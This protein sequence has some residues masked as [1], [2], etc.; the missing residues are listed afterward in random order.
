[1]I[2]LQGAGRVTQRQKSTFAGLCREWKQ[3]KPDSINFQREENPRAMTARA[4]AYDSIV[5][6]PKLNVNVE[7][8]EEIKVVHFGVV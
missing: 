4:T 7:E 2:L 8:G 3:L 1:M 5:S 6:L